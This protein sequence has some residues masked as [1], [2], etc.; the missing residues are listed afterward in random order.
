M[1]KFALPDKQKI[2]EA[3]RETMCGM[4]SRQGSSASA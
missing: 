1:E 3:V 4:E 2:I